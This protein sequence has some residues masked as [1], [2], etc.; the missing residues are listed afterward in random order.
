[1]RLNLEINAEVDML[2]SKK[3][4]KQ[5]LLLDEA[6]SYEEWRDAAQQYSSK[7]TKNTS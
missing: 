5:Q 7:N 6:E 2:G 3:L 1:M 4:E